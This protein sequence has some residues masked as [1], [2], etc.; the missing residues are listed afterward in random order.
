[1]DMTLRCKQSEFGNAV[2]ITQQAVSELIARGVLTEG[3]T[4]GAWLLEYCGNLREVAADRL[5]NGG[6]DL[7]TE[8]AMLARSQREKIE[9]QNEVMR[10]ALAPKALLSQVLSAAAPKMCGKIE[11][12]V[13]TLRRRASFSADDL[14]FV[15][16]NIAEA[17]NAIACLSLPEILD[18]ATCG[19]DSGPI[20]DD[21][22]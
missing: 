14:D 11:T 22:P 20:S 15:A 19:D 7:A 2:G 12:I 18:D 4:A 3:A 17:C 21:E 10:R 16:R 5:G 13:P 8:R 1:M 6:L 9:M